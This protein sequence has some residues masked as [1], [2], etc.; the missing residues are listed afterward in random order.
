[1]YILV[2]DDE[3]AVLH[4]QTQEIR[5]VFP[6]AEIHEET[7]PLSALAWSREL[8]ERGEMLSYAFLDVRMQEMDGIGLARQLRAEHPQVTLL[9]CSAFGE[10]AIDAYGLFAKGYLLKPIA[11]RDIVAMLDAM[12]P[13]WRETG[14]EKHVRVQTFGHFD[15]YV[16]KEPITDMAGLEAAVK[17]GSSKDEG[18][19]QELYLTNMYTSSTDPIYGEF[20]MEYWGEAYVYIVNA[21]V[22][23]AAYG[24][25]N[26]GI[27]IYGYGL[28]ASVAKS[29]E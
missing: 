4:D 22:I 26:Y 23:D 13:S 18:S 27:V 20:P 25:P 10:Y 12:V 21:A 15:V 7:N 29:A 14:S 24:D 9:F 3:I 1:M 17:I 6:D 2:V 16:S 28:E 5:Q 19:A 8:K 11:G